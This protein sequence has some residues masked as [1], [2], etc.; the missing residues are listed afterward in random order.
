MIEKFQ[1]QLDRG[2]SYFSLLV[3]LVMFGNCIHFFLESMDAELFKGTYFSE[4]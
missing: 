2:M 1:K 3:V 4:S